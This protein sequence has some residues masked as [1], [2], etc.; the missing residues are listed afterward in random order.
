M[1]AARR[2]SVQSVICVTTNDSNI[3]TVVS[4]FNRHYGENTIRLVHRPEILCGPN[5]ST[6]D[7]MVHALRVIGHE[8][9]VAFERICLLQPTSPARRNRLLDTCISRLEGSSADSLLTVSE[10]TPFF[11]KLDGGVGH[12][13]CSER[14][15]RQNLTP[16]EMLY[17]DNGNVYINSVDRFLET[18]RITEH[19]LLHT[20]PQFDSMQ[21]DTEDDFALME[22]AAERYG[23]FL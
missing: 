10:H 1:E 15:M 16:E 8:D 6:E 19:P 22:L 9:D 11:W 2:A 7:A 4:H 20:I 13:Q 23:G 14:K 18:G 17:H 5:S 12:A 21:I 3:R